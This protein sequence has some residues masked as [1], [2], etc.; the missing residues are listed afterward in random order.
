MVTR[1]EV[2]VIVPAR[3]GSKS[4]TRK[5]IR[6]FAGHPLLAYSVAAGLQ[7]ETVSR[8]IVSTDDE[9]F[10]EVARHYGAEIPFIR[11]QELAADDSLDLPVFCHA[12]EWLDT[13]EDYHPE[14]VVQLRPTSPTRPRGCVDEAVNMLLASPEADSVRGV[15]PSGQNPYKMWRLTD[16][17][18]MEPLLQTDFDEPYNMPRQHLPE[19]YWQTGHIDAIRTKTILEKGSMSGDVILPLVLDPAYTVDI[20]TIRDWELAEWQLLKG[21]LDA[22]RPGKSPRPLPEK[23]ELVVLDFDGVLTDNRVWVDAEGHE[24]VAA[25]RGDGLGLE[26]LREEGI[27]IVVLSRETNPVV[28]ARCRKLG[29]PFVQGLSD[30]T[31]ALKRWMKES[32][33]DAAH[34]I[35]LGNDVNDTPCFPLVGCAGVVADAHPQ[36]RTQADF[37]LSKK[38]GH[39]A[40]RELCDILLLRMRE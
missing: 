35:Y 4:I 2:L 16:E 24:L 17:S 20:D 27:K 26:L 21:E 37:V 1:P 3:G 25:N 39:G 40:V 8:V 9:S 12:L 34:V 6:P 7:A 32:G 28:E 38:G 31:E 5:N 36:A 14:I 11:P 22:V 33:T 30:K 10:A 15:V 19:T 13:N 23:V 29:L 18:G